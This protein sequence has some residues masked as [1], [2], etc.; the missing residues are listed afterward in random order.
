MNWPWILQAAGALVLFGGA[1][2][3]IV[4]GARFV[5]SMFRKVSE[6]LDD[7]RGEPARHGRAAVPGV[8]ERLVRLEEMALEVAHEVKPN[9]GTSLKDQITQIQEHTVPSEARPA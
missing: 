9:S 5:A 8:M 2:A 6:F 4:K 3:V 7:W 1:V